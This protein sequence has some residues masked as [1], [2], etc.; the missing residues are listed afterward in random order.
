MSAITEAIF[1][2]ESV[3]RLRHKPTVHERFPCCGPLVPSCLKH[4]VPSST[5]SAILSDIKTEVNIKLE[6]KYTLN[7]ANLKNWIL[8][9]MRI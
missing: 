5:Q 2:T 7:S 6:G 9:E 4:S 1:C 3:V 8:I